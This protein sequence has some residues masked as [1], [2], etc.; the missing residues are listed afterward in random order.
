MIWKPIL[1]FT[2]N[3]YILILILFFNTYIAILLAKY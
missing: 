3:G 2:F 1:W